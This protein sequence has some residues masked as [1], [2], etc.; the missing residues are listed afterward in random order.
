MMHFMMTLARF[1]LLLVTGLMVLGVGNVY[2]TPSDFAG[3]GPDRANKI[4][5]YIDDLRRGE[6]SSAV[7]TMRVKTAHYTRSM[8]MDA[9][10]KG[11]EKSL[12]RIVS[13]LKEK[14]TATLKSDNNIFSYLPRTDRTIR[15][16]SGMMM[17][18]WMGSHFTNDDLVKDSRREDDY[19]ST[20]SFEGIRD[21]QSIIEFTLIP[22]PDAAVVWGK[23]VLVIVDKKY[24]PLTEVYYDEDMLVARSITFSDVKQLGGQMRPAVMRVVPTDK[25]DEFTELV[26]EKLEMNIDISD[27][28]FSIANLRRK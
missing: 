26:Y 24:I 11:K 19:I 15:L 10:S 20:I 21:G 5:R 16:T 28:F 2:S 1:F 18:S 9:W 12:V 8:K 17:G 23:V 7:I 25:P 6:S 13:P 27:D 22:K 14:G 4:L 3:A